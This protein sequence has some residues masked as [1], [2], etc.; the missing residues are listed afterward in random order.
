MS[1]AM[2]TA[3]R[4]ATCGSSSP[5]SPPR[6]V[7][8]ESVEPYLLRA[9]ARHRLSGVQR[10]VVVTTV[11]FKIRPHQ[12]TPLSGVHAQNLPIFA[13][14]RKGCRAATASVGEPFVLQIRKNRFKHLGAETRVI[15][16][17]PKILSPLICGRLE[18]I[19][20]LFGHFGEG[21]QS[22]PQTSDDRV[23]PWQIRRA[24]RSKLVGKALAIVA[25]CFGGAKLFIVC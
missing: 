15:V 20:V 19:E 1:R 9:R 12:S 23:I 6:R 25:V 21:R 16:V 2:R 13:D 3:A 22:L 11:L 14:L 24:R 17:G 4:R 7:E 18:F 5:R 8:K 10:S